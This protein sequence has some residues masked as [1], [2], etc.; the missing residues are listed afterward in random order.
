MRATIAQEATRAHALLLLCE[1]AAGARPAHAIAGATFLTEVAPLGNIARPFP[2]EN[3]AWG[4][5]ACASPSDPGRSSITR[6]H[7]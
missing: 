3:L 2:H 6:R 7:R 4:A 1:L 5:S